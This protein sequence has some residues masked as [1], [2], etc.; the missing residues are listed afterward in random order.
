MNKTYEGFLDDKKQLEYDILKLLQAF[1]KNYGLG[2]K[3]VNLS[4]YPMVGERH[5]SVRFVK[6]DVEV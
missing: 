5:E 4:Q 2:V 6:L 3:Y 1:E